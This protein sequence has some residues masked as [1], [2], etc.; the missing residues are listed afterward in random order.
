MKIKPNKLTWSE[1]KRTSFP[2]MPNLHEGS[3]ADVIDLWMEHAFHANESYIKYL[4]SYAMDLVNRLNEL[5]K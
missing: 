4:E 5:E 1:W 2:G 3:A